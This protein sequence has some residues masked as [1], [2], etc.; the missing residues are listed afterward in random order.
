MLP[1]GTNCDG[2]YGQ[3]D[4]TIP[5][6]NTSLFRGRAAASQLGIVRIDIQPVV[7]LNDTAYTV[8]DIIDDVA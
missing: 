7:F 5:G 1:L 4:C 8:I 3:N 6:V 2:V